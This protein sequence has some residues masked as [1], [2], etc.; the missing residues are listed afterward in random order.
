MHLIVFGT[1]S[2]LEVVMLKVI[3]LAF[4]IL[5]FVVNYQNTH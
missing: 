5:D 3:I 2:I 4:V 1:S